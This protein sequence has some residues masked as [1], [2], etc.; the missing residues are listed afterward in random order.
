MTGT[1]AFPTYNDGIVNHAYVAK[2]GTYTI[3]AVTDYTIDCTANTFTVTLP[4]AVGI[5]GQLFVIKNSGSGT[6]TVDTTSSQTIDGGSS[7]TITAGS[8]ATLQSNNAN[9]IKL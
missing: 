5:Q 8:S 1:Q 6:I 2:T 9:Y 7:I 4:T 3:S